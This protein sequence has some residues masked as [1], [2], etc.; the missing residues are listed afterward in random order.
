VPGLT[1]IT[2][3]NDLVESVRQFQA[4][5][6]FKRMTVLAASGLM[7]TEPAL[8]EL[9]RQQTAS[10]GVEIDIVAVGTS[11][12]EVVSAIPS[13]TEAVYVTPLTHLP[14]GAFDRLVNILIERRLPSFSYW[15]RSEVD[16]GLLTSTHLPAD[17]QRLGRRVAVNIQRILMGDDPAMFPVDLERGSR[18]TINMATARAIG[19]YPSWSMYTDAELLH[20]EQTAT[21][22]LGLSAVAR[23]AIQVNLDLAAT[24]RSVAGGAEEIRKARASFLPQLGISTS[25]QMVDSDRA[26]LSFG[27]LPQFGIRGSATVRQLI[28]SEQARANLDIQRHLQLSREQQYEQTRLDIVLAASTAYLNVLRAKTFERVARDNLMLTRSHLEHARTRQELGV[29]RLAEVVRWENELA[30]ARRSVIDATT[31]ESLAGV[32]LNRLLDHPLEEPFETMDAGL[33]DSSLYTTAKKLDPYVNN[34]FAQGIFRDFMTQ[35]GLALSPELKQL[36][37]AIEAQSRTLLASRRSFVRPEVALVADW[38]SDI[39]SAGAGNYSL[40]DISLPSEIELSDSVQEVIDTLSLN[41][42]NWS[43]GVSASLPL[44]T[45]G[46][47]RAQRAQAVQDLSRVRLERASAADRIEQRIRSAL[48]LAGASYAGI[49]LAGD[50]ADAARRNLELLTSAY[51]EGVVSLLDLLD[52]QNTQIVSDEVVANAVYDYLIDLMNAQRAVGRFDFFVDPTEQQALLEEIR[53]YFNEVGYV[54]PHHN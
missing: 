26:T 5:S 13:N 19:I 10:V 42:V 25:T 16:G 30:N 8:L 40:S 2:F 48:H 45:G 31:Q 53:V 7:S 28:Y 22:R 38:S 4:V 15:G 11:I 9:M 32:E 41:S 37:A 6:P 47:R 51:R 39:F 3:S 27:A 24:E 49:E 33:E 54:L 44:F 43:V 14:F 46:T 50:A 23:E 17:F 52:A 36:D 18:L 20:L 21:R 12:D 1:Y 34:F 35:L 29:A